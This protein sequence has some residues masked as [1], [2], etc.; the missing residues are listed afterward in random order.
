M[1]VRVR[2][3]RRARVPPRGPGPLLHRPRNFTT[4]PA[5]RAGLRAKTGDEEGVGGG[6]RPSSQRCR[7]VGAQLL[8][9]RCLFLPRRLADGDG[10]GYRAP[11]LPDDDKE[12][13]GP[14]RTRPLESARRLARSS[15]TSSSRIPSD[16]PWPPCVARRVLVEKD[17]TAQLRSRLPLDVVVCLARRWSRSSV[18]RE[19]KRPAFI[20][21]YLWD[22]RTY[23]RLS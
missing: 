23:P 6:H 21:R 5:R 22:I 18:C 4:A 8:D 19:R 15:E 14:G 10:H 13:G 16:R 12:T 20:F 11:P 17:W 1:R 9:L 2:L 7:D 3:A